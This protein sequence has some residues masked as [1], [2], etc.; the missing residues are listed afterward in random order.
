MSL[1][2]AEGLLTF[3]LGSMTWQWIEGDIQS[4][5]VASNVAQA[6]SRRLQTL[7]SQ[8][9]LILQ[10]TSCIGNSFRQEM[11]EFVLLGIQSMYQTEWLDGV[12]PQGDVDE[13]LEELIGMGVIET[14]F[15]QGRFDFAHDQ[16]QAAAFRSIPKER[17]V[18][19]Q[20][21]IGKRLI[22][23][24]DEY[25][26]DKFLF[27]AVEL[28][29]FGAD[30]LMSPDELEHFSFWSFVAGDTALKQGAFDTA[31]KFFEQS[32]KCLGKHAF[33]Q[34]KELALPVFSGAAEAAYCVGSE[35]VVEYIEMVQS[36][37]QITEAD[38]IRV[39]L[40]QMKVLSGKRDF[41][42]CATAFRTMSKGLGAAKF[43]ANPGVFGALH[44]LTKAT[45]LM[46]KYSREQFL[47]LPVCRDPSTKGVL[48]AFTTSSYQLY[49]SNPN[50]FIMGCCQA[51]QW[52]IKKGHSKST[53][54]ALAALGLLVVGIS[55]DY[56]KAL[57]I[58][59]TALELC[60]VYA[61]KAALP[62][63]VG[64]VFGFIRHWTKPMHEF[65]TPMRYAID[66]GTRLGLM[67][68][69]AFLV[70]TYGILLILT[71]TNTLAASISTKYHRYSRERQH[72]P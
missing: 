28:C 7:S 48:N 30:K 39:S 23:G 55:G 68:D 59:E 4:H 22:E 54:S 57:K 70:N 65:L 27:T 62:Q 14:Q 3:D 18:H 9:L 32:A 31:L 66:I 58:G 5:H 61:Y 44:M 25:H 43:R 45:R 47:K 26:R 71:Q 8:E 49:L 35:K 67:D 13:L 34:D 36:Q 60:E 11:L 64:L 29:G 50:L 63:T 51:V 6:V 40:I 38:K 10:V 56:A 24:L 52:S 33:A 15:E 1:L 69:V 21:A 17:K 19:M 37:T 20:M 12:W 16:I 72:R 41:P 2:V 42:G 53:P 46:Q